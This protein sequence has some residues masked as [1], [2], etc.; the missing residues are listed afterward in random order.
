MANSRKTAAKSEFNGMRKRA[1]MAKNP[2]VDFLI[3]DPHLL[4][5][6]SALERKSSIRVDLNESV[7]GVDR[8]FGTYPRFEN[9]LPFCL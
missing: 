5:G 1:K 8:S 4:A 7:D 2:L 6:A 9:E 3:G